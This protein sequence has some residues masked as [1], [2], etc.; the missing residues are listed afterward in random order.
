MNGNEKKIL[1]YKL[2]K[3]IICVK[4]KLK[5]F[6]DDSWLNFKKIHELLDM[7]MKKLWTEVKDVQ[8]AQA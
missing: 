5:L 8:Q 4:K 7:L 3:S 6:N 2:D 1:D